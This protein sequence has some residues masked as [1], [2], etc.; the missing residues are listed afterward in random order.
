[1][2]GVLDFLPAWTYW[3]IGFALSEMICRVWP[4]LPDYEE[5]K[6]HI[7]GWAGL[8]LLGTQVLVIVLFAV[9]AGVWLAFFAAFFGLICRYAWQ[10]V[11]TFGS[12]GRL[13]EVVRYLLERNRAREG[14]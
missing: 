8:K 2:I 1:M 7:D 10:I 3:P 6:D 4:E 14:M 12:F 5:L 11:A 13:V 9:L